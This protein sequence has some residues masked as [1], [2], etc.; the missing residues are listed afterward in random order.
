[1][2][3][4]TAKY[5]L[6]SCNVFMREFCSVVS[7]AGAVVDPEFLELGLHENPA[8]LRVRLQE[9]IDDISAAPARESGGR[10]YDAILLGYGL[11]G[12]GLAG[13]YARSLPLVLSRAHDCCTILLGSRSAFQESFGS[14]LSASWSSAG[15]IERGATYFRSSD[16][17][18]SSGR[19]LEYAQL[20]E[21][22]GEDNAVY[23]WETLHPE[24][25]EKEMRFIETPETAALGYADVM[26]RRAAEEGKGFVLLPGSTRLLRALVAGEWNESDFLVVPP[27]RRIE[28]VWDDGRVIDAV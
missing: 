15:Y 16:A 11:C 26:R 27:G 6:I 13:V 21:R 4:K 18:L 24:D 22:Y 1:M 20:V 9:R 5:K 17:G 23:I 28:P 10:G 12:N 25:R 7:A 2:T 19:G 8:E 3:G 14:N